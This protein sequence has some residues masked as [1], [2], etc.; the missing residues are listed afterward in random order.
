MPPL[1]VITDAYIVFQRIRSTIE[2]HD[3]GCKI[4]VKDTTGTATQAAIAAKVAAT[5]QADMLPIIGDFMTMGETEV[6][7]L[8]GHSSVNTFVTGAFGAAGSWPG[9]TALPEC[10]A[11]GVTWQTGVRG[12]SHRGRNYV[13]GPSTDMPVNILKRDLTGAATTAIGTAAGNFLRDLAIG[14]GAQLALQVLS[15]K[16]GII[17]PVINLRPNGG[18]VEQRRRYEKVAHR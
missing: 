6:T 17:T 13:P 10:L 11:M 16:L 15:K 1:P 2:L 14:A 3:M 7:A 4:C 8:D 12:R 5:W 9:G 18:L